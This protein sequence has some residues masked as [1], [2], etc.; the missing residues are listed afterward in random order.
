MT[1]KIFYGTF[2]LIAGILHSG[3]GLLFLIA[4][5]DN[6]TRLYTGIILIAAGTLLMIAG[7]RLFRKGMITRPGAVE[8]AILK[9]AAKKNGRISEE[10]L[11]AETGIRDLTIF[12]LNKMVSSKRAS[13]ET[14]AQGTFYTFPEFQF[15][16][17][18][19]ACPYCGNDYPVRTDVER[20]PSCGGDLKI[21]GSTVSGDDRFSMDL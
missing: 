5:S 16:L 3:M 18:F 7:Y 1:S 10:A 2:L 20:C 13:R 14:S 12:E 17:K 4:S 11:I 6:S 21:T 8:A 15:D 19:K 9:A